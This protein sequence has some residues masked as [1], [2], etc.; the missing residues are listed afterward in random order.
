[1]VRQYRRLCAVLARE[2][3]ESPLPETDATYRTALQRT[4]ER[5]R[6]AASVIEP[7]PTPVLVAVGH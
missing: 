7:M 4:V 3:D 1:M 5:S 6:E 2:L